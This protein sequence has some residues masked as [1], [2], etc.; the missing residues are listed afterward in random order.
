M[1]VHYKTGLDFQKVHYG[2]ELA[3]ESKSL[4]KSKNEEVPEQVLFSWALL[5]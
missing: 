1:V 2:K 5:E 4:N 3:L